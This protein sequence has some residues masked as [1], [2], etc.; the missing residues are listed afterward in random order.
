LPKGEGQ[1]LNNNVHVSPNTANIRRGAS[2]VRVTP[3]SLA[4]RKR[5]MTAAR[6]VFEREGYIDARVADIATLA[7]VSHGSFYT[8]FSDK[9]DVFL[10][11]IKVAD[12]ER[13]RNFLTIPRDLIHDPVAALE[14]SNRQYLETFMSDMRLQLA[15][16]Q[17]SAVTP[18]V[19]QIG[20]E[21]RL[22]HVKQ[23]TNTIER[24]Q[25]RGLAD[26]DVNAAETAAAL[27]CMRTEFARYSYM[28]G[29]DYDLDSMV[30]TVTRIWVRAVG[31]RRSRQGEKF[32]DDTKRGRLHSPDLADPCFGTHMS[33]HSPRVLHWKFHGG[34][35]PDTHAIAAQ[36]PGR[37]AM[38]RNF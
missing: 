4:T 26:P 6:K 31:L 37:H 33:I 7:G 28:R 27:I 1:G 19:S 12:E 20:F 35:Q 14:Y 17:A 36:G 24:W 32:A 23:L 15:I 5:L 21:I 38:R 22:K 10:E 2:G 25:R 30:D 13:T 3:R 16:Q 34:C 8:H 9:L 29:T 18:E 11:V